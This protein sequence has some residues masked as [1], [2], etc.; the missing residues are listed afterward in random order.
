MAE[1]DFDNK[2]TLQQPLTSERVLLSNDESRVELLH[3]VVLQ[4][5][6]FSSGDDWELRNYRQ[7]FTDLERLIRFAVQGPIH[8]ET[9]RV[10]EYYRPMKNLHMTNLYFLY[11]YISAYQIEKIF[12]YY[13]HRPVIRVTK[14]TSYIEVDPAKLYVTYKAVY[15]KA[16]LV[17]STRPVRP[18]RSLEAYMPP[19]KHIAPIMRSI[20]TVTLWSTDHDTPLL[21]IEASD[22][23]NETNPRFISPSFVFTLREWIISHYVNAGYVRSPEQPD[24]TEIHI[25]PH[26]STTN[27]LS[28]T[29]QAVL[30]TQVCAGDFYTPIH[31]MLASSDLETAAA[32]W[33]EFCSVFDPTDA[34][35]RHW[36]VYKL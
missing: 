16:F 2:I 30:F 33:I 29:E 25:L 26:A 4:L 6:I 22:P 9:T 23:C 10:V 27:L 17:E 35:G 7:T 5:K 12:K 3:D 18:V 1:H 31:D 11:K 14:P 24:G 19:V 13:V 32:I 20:R 15:P 8:Y 36:G 34:Y 21:Q 28:A